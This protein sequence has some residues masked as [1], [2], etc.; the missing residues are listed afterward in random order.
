MMT[1]S[2][3]Q[4][5]LSGTKM[6][7]YSDDLREQTLTPDELCKVLADHGQYLGDWLMDHGLAN[8]DA[9]PAETDGGAVADW[10]GY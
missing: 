10:L 7:T 5:W 2:G 4:A 3:N 1:R 8:V 6:T 9:M